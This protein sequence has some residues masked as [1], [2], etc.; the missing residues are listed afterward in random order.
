MPVS[1]RKMKKGSRRHDSLIDDEHETEIDTYPI[2]DRQIDL[3]PVPYENSSFLR[4]LRYNRYVKMD[5]LDCAR[6]VGL[7]SMKGS[8]DVAHRLRLLHPLF[9]MSKLPIRVKVSQH[10]SRPLQKR[11]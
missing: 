5:A 11:A 7:I 8:V 3:R 6:F 9:L 10:S 1:S 4:P 2:M